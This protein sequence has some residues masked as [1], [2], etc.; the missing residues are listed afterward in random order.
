MNRIFE[1]TV[2]KGKVNLDLPDLYRSLVCSLEGKRVKITLGIVRRPRSGNQNRYL[3]G[4]VY[5]LLGDYFGYTCEE[6]HEVMKM[7]L[8][9]IPG[10]DGKPDRIGSTAK[11]DTGE[12]ENYLE[13][14]RQWAAQKYGFYIPLPNEVEF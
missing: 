12:M 11:L 9:K 7:E 5:K 14:I 4:V 10:E 6:M 8:L 3:W 2:K 13:K 1:G